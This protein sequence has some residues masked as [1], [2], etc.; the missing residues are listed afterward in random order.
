MCAAASKRGT[1]GARKG[2]GAARRREKAPSRTTPAPGP[3]PGAKRRPGAG[4]RQTEAP[5]L[6]GLPDDESISIARRVYVTLR[7]GLMAGAIMPGKPL[8]SRSLS[9]ALGVSPTPVREALKQL[10]ADGAL[11]SRSKSAFFVS[12]PDQG[13]YEEI[14]EL[15]LSL[16]GLAIR[17]AALAATQRDVV[18]LRKTN[19]AYESALKRGRPHLHLALVPNFEFHFQMYGLAGSTML[20]GMIESTWSRIGPALHSFMMRADAPLLSSDAHWRMVEALAANDPEA[21]ERALRQDIEGAAEVIL[22]ALR[23]R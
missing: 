13:E 8:T 6:P 20:V 1:T 15:R 3:L 18:R 22:P 10:E 11:T 7:Q 19:K 2:G 21:A 17:K 5:E 14:V 23:P 9:Q 12:D 4:R 16:E